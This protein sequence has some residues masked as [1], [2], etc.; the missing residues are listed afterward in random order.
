MLF[1][2][3]AVFVGIV[4][5]LYPAFYISSI[6]VSKVL[7]GKFENRAS[8]HAFRKVL[9]TVQ[10]SLSIFVIMGMLIMDQQIDFLK[11]KGRVSR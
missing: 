5:G 4:S 8:S 6:P 1:I 2:F 10:F 11:N 3:V 9:I 7:Q